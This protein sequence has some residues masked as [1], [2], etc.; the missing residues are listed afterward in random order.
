MA[1]GWHALGGSL[2]ILL[3]WVTLLYSRKLTEHCKP[4]VMEKIKIIINEKKKYC[5]PGISTVMQWVKNESDCSSLGCFRSVGLIPS[6]TQWVKGSTAAAAM[7]WVTAAA[8]ILFL[9]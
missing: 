8:Q 1:W 9:A 6:L 3:S 5:I 4:A 7:E 2:K